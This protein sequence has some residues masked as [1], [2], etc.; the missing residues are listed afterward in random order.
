MF[1]VKYIMLR[2]DTKRRNDYD[3]PKIKKINT[4]KKA[5]FLK[6]YNC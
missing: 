5:Y 6:S 1:N 3:I 2:Y 4:T